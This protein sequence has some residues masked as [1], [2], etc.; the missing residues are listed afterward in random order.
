MFGVHRPQE[1][2]GQ[3]W[4]GVPDDAQGRSAGHGV[5]GS[6]A[7][8]RQS[9]VG[10]QNRTYAGHSGGIQEAVQRWWPRWIVQ[11]HV[12]DC[13][14]A[15]DDPLA[16]VRRAW[17]RRHVRKLRQQRTVCPKYCPAGRRALP[18]AGRV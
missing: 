18:S 13:Q 16:S 3:G 2:E 4:S 6:G 5:Q 7:V 12:R 11:D 15:G 8:G 10:E 1:E 14:A 9:A 17:C